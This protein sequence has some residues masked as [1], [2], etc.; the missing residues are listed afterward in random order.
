M[1]FKRVGLRSYSNCGK[2]RTRQLRPGIYISERNWH[3]QEK[4][5]HLYAPWCFIGF[6]KTEREARANCRKHASSK[7]MIDAK[8]IL[9][10]LGIPTS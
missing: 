6:A 5:I 10:E 9:K 7:P 4:P 2:Y 3:A 8:E 1:E